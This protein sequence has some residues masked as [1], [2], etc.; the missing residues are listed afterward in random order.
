[1]TQESLILRINGSE[2]HIDKRAVPSESYGIAVCAVNRVDILVYRKCN[3]GLCQ[4][5]EKRRDAQLIVGWIEPM[6]R[7]DQKGFL[8]RYVRKFR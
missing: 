7:P 8:D 3:N 1:M 4:V 5:L 6:K 2:R